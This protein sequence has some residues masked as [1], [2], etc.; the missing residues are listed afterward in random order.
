MQAQL[1]SFN[2]LDL[3]SKWTEDVL[4]ENQ[5]KIKAS[6]SEDI[7]R[8]EKKE[9]CMVLLKNYPQESGVRIFRKQPEYPSCLVFIMDFC[10]LKKHVLS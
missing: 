4:F 9:F 3:R 7:I 6:W 10:S 1:C 8:I 5:S 2:R